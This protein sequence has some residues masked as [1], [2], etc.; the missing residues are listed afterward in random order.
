M[1]KTLKDLQVSLPWTAHYHRDFRQTPMTHKHFA[2]ALLHVHKAAG[3]LAGIIDQAEHAGYD[4]SL[5][6]NRSEVQKYLADLVV[7]ALRMSNTC[8]DGQ[9][10]LQFAVENRIAAKNNQHNSLQCETPLRVNQ[11]IPRNSQTCAGCRELTITCAACK[12]LTIPYA[13]SVPFCKGCF[14]ERYIIQTK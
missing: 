11:D 8:P 1:T 12:K 7:C 5:M 9:I 3:K 13:A 6:A 10:D 14:L 2:H 4:W